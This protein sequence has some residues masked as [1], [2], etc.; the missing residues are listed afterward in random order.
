MKKSKCM[1]IVALLIALNITTI[2][3][4]KVSGPG[5]PEPWGIAQTG[6]PGTPEPWGMII[7]S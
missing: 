2:G 3:K 7:N 1:I 6:G 4:F 5:T